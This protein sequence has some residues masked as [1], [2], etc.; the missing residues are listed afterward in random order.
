MIKIKEDGFKLLKGTINIKAWE[1]KSDGTEELI[2][3]KTFD[4]L[5]VNVGKKSILK[6]LGGPTIAC[7][8]DSGS[9]DDI[10]T[11]DSSTAPGAGDTDL[12]GCPNKLWKAILTTDKVFVCPTLFVSVDFGYCCANWTWN[13]LGLRD[14][15]N[16][17]WA[18]Q[19]D[20]TPLVKTASKRAIIEWQL[21][22]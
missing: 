11:G 3:D 4:N 19:T 2:K 5:I 20:C 16:V 13:E 7:C 18:R 8:A 6:Y 10:G 1:K 9:V 22:L 17:L 15:N 21:S 12:I 14:T